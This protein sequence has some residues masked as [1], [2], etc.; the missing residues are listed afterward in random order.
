MLAP[1]TAN[2]NNNSFLK[3][4]D[5]MHASKSNQTDALISEKKIN[6]NFVKNIPTTNILFTLTTSRNHC[7]RWKNQNH[8]ASTHVACQSYD[9]TDP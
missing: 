7:R 5:V 9:S 1:R 8:L 6:Q 2:N 3:C 4:I